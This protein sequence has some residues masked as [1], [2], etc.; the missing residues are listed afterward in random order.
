MSAASKPS[1]TSFFCFIADRIR[2]AGNTA[3]FALFTIPR[4]RFMCRARSGHPCNLLQIVSIIVSTS[5]SVNGWFLSFFAALL[6]IENNRENLEGDESLWL[7]EVEDLLLSDIGVP[8]ERKL[9]KDVSSA[10]IHSNAVLCS[11]KI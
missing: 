10:S 6:L 3:D 9:E 1:G 11:L 8:S 4:A 7:E 5:L 2:W